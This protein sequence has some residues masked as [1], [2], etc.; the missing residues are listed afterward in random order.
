[1]QVILVLYC[2]ITQMYKTGAGMTHEVKEVV[3]VSGC[4]RLLFQDV[5][6][7][8]AEFFIP[9]TV[10]QEAKLVHLQQVTW[11]RF[12]LN[13]RNS[14]QFYDGRHGCNATTAPGFQSHLVTTSNPPEYKNKMGKEVL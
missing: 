10:Q 8:H 7:A 1:M 2:L 3:S 4:I 9:A 6:V 11:R 5:N 12:S 13:P 14:V